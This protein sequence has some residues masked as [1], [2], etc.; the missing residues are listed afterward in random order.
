MALHN[1]MHQMQMQ[2]PI[3]KRNIVRDTF[4]RRLGFIKPRAATI[5]S[6]RFNARHYAQI[7]Q[8]PTPSPS[9]RR[10][11]A[12][13]SLGGGLFGKVTNG[14]LTAG[15]VQKYWTAIGISAANHPVVYIKLLDGAR[16]LPK[17]NDGGSTA[18]NTLDVATIGACCPGA[19][20]IIIMYVAPNSFSGFYN[21]FN[22]AINGT[23]VVNGVTVAPKIVSCS[24]GASEKSWPPNERTRYNALFAS[25]VAK[26]INITAASGDYGSS[27]GLPGLNV[28]Y[29]AASPNVI[30]C[31]GT[32]LVCPT[33]SYSGAGTLETTWTGSGGGVSTVFA[34][35][36]YQ[37]S[38]SGDKRVVPDIAMNADPNTGVQF[39]LNG[40]TVVYGGTSI[41]S[42]AM[43]GYIGCLSTTPGFVNGTLY[44]NTNCFHDI[45]VGN[46][47]GFQAGGG[48]DRCTGL[49]SPNGALLTPRLL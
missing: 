33:R 48:Y 15:D 39:F 8:F 12:V 25:A 37:N 46:N 26:G 31:G 40:N 13:I 16:N 27:N 28:D 24:W 42:P 38:L 17:T 1:Y 30:A 34:K 32:T 23:V 36:A 5:S 45:T 9:A 6:A 21:A 41:V 19:R 47:G 11:F 3:E 14:I 10:V 18:E 20:N 2:G 29:P 35:P 43:A 4:Y 22:A 7:Y 44:N 49:G